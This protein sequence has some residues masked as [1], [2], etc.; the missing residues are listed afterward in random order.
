MS[1]NE[2]VT[3]RRRSDTLTPVTF[4]FPDHLAPHPQRVAVV[5]SFNGWDPKANPL[6]KTPEGT[7][8]ATL[9]LPPCRVVY[10][11]DVDGSA[12][13]DPDE[14]ARVVG[15]RGTEYSSRRVGQRPEHSG[16]QD[17]LSPPDSDSAPDGVPECRIDELPNAVVVRPS[18]RLELSTVSVFR[19]WLRAAVLY[20][21]HVIVDMT[22]VTHIDGPG[23]LELLVVRHYARTAGRLLVLAALRENVGKGIA[24]MDPEHHLA[25]V[26]SVETAEHLLRSAA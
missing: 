4:E 14:D 10:R 23:V 11:F 9:Y 26:P 3:D 22:R 24:A 7:W 8:T 2:V 1:A 17:P 15:A 6:A 20:E 21:R 16:P 13:L 12:W 5:G 25:I 19:E 18:G